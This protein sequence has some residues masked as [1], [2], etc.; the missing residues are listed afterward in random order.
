MWFYRYDQGEDAGIC[1]GDCSSAQRLCAP[2]AAPKSSNNIVPLAVKV[3]IVD[4][5]IFTIKTFFLS[6]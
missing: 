3:I 6:H 5:V 2:S 1:C 4:K